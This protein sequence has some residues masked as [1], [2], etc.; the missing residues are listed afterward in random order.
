MGSR[1]DQIPVG[2]A[3]DDGCGLLAA[4]AVDEAPELRGW[5]AWLEPDADT[6]E[7]DPPAGAAGAALRAA[8]GSGYGGATGGGAHAD[9][10]RGAGRAEGM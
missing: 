9:G 8:V 10:R 2:E 7:P 5:G 6:A 1:D 3:P 4:A